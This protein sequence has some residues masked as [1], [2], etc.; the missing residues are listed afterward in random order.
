AFY[1]WLTGRQNLRRIDAAGPDG[2]RKTRTARIDAA[3]TK[4]G[5]AA[6][7]TK[8]YRAYSLGMKQR[9]GLAAALLRPRS[10]LVLDEP[11]NGMDPQGTREIRNLVRELA[12][13]GSTVFLSTHLLSEVE[14]LCT[15]L[16]IISVGKVVAQ[17]SI[18]DLRGRGRADSGRGRGASLGREAEPRIE[19]ALL[20]PDHQQRCLR[21]SRRP[22][23]H[24]AVL[25]SPRGRDRRWRRGGRRGEP[26]HA[27][28]PA[29]SSGRA[30]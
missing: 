19:T 29:V 12:S 30:D 20:R 27:A 13:E 18:E 26:R 14:Q 5:L 8:R 21:R 7:A 10:L 15:H 1:P 4:V 28:I 2:Q 22:H 23:G 17:G 16:G 11:T 25:P 9:L 6:A 3:L 24:A